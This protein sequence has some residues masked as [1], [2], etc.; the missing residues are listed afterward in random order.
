MLF[1]PFDDPVGDVAAIDRGPMVWDVPLAAVTAI[2]DLFRRPLQT[3]VGKIHVTDGERVSGSG[4]EKQRGPDVVEMKGGR[5]ADVALRPLRR[6][7]APGHLVP[8]PP[9]HAGIGHSAA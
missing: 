2:L 6:R 9:P 8:P 7:G 1:E 3:E 5:V 4:N